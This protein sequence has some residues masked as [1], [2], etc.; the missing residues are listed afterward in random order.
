MDGE[1]K[2]NIRNAKLL[3][4]FRIIQSIANRREGFYDDDDDRDNESEHEAIGSKM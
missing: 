3:K 4:K 1:A 2:Q